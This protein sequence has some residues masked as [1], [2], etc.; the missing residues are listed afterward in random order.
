[1]LKETLKRQYPELIDKLVTKESWDKMDDMSFCD[2]SIAI[3]ELRCRTFPDDP[4]PVERLGEAYHFRKNLYEAGKYYKKVLEMDHPQELSKSEIE[5]VLQY[6][7]ILHTTPSEYFKLMDVIAIHHPEKPL[8]AYHLFWEDDYNFPDDYDPCD[9]EQVWVSYSAESGQVNGVWS[10]YHTHLLS[11]QEAIEEA[12]T[13]QGH[14]IIRVEWGIHGSLVNNW[15]SLRLTEA[16]LTL[17]EFLKHT[18]ANAVKGGRMTEHPIK[19]RW[20]KGFEGNFEDYLDFSHEIRT[21]E[22]LKSKKMVLKSRWSNAVIQNYFLAY[23]FA[24][25]YDWP[26]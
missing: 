18:F 9:H 17:T 3:H 11:T 21:E 25:K 5:K 6:A 7:P 19:K 16:D 26:F 4:E 10:F 20:P 12:N 22:L 13:N 1:M 14:P 24:P 15:E 2:L 23:N 8:I